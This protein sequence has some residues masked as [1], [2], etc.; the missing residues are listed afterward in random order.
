MLKLVCESKLP[1]LLRNSIFFSAL[2]E[3][4]RVDEKL[5]FPRRESGSVDVLLGD[6]KSAYD[7]LITS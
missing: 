7:S 6:P 5:N 4:E 2:G 1:D 3:G